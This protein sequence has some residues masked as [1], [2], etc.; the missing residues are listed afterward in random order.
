MEDRYNRF[1]EQ[2]SETLTHTWAIIAL[3]L[4]LAI[5]GH[6]LLPS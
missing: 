5:V 4:A 2:V 1:A 6:V 3:A